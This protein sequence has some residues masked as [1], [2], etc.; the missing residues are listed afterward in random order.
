[1]D[2]E[3]MINILAMK[4]SMREEELRATKLKLK[5]YD[6]LFFIMLGSFTVVC[7]GFV[8]VNGD[9]PPPK[10]T[11]DGVEQTY[12]PTTAKEKLARK[13][14]LKAR[15]TLLMALPNEYQL[16]FNS[17]KNAKS[18]MEAIEK[19]FRGNKESKKTHKTLIKQQYENF[20]GSSSE[21][22]DQTYD[23]LQKLIRQLQILETLSMDDLYNN[24]K[25]YETKVKGSSSSSQNLQ[26]G[27]FMSSN[28]SGSFNQAHG[29]NS[30]NTDSLKEMDLKWQ[31]A[32]LT[33][34]ARRFIKKT[35]RKV[36]ANGYETIKFEK[37]KVEC[38]N[39][40]KRGHFAREYKA[41]KENKKREPVR[42]NVT[43]ETTDAKALV[44]QDGIRYDW[45]DQAKDGPT[46][47]VLMA[48]TSSGSL[49]SS[50]SDS[51]VSDSEDENETETKSKQ[52]KSSFDKVE[53][54]KPNE[55]VKS[56]RES[57]KQV[58]HN[59][60]A[61]H[62]RKNNQSPRGLESVEARLVIYKKNEDIFEENTKILK[63][64][65]HLRDNALT[66]LRKKLEKV[67]DSEDENETETKS[68]QRKSS[69]DKVEFVK[70]NEQV[71]SLRES[72]K[73]KKGVIDSGFSRHMTRNMSYLSEYE[74]I[75]GGY[76][77]FEGDS[78]VG[79][80]D[81]KAD[82]VFF[83]GYSVNSKAFR[84]LNSRTKIIKET[85]H[86][87]FLENKPNVTGS[88]PTWLLDIDT[89]TKSMNYKPVVVGNKSN[90]SADPLF[91]SSS[92]DSPGD[93]FKPSREEEKK[94]AEDPG[95][96]DNE[97]LS[98]E[99]P[100]VNQEKD[101]NVNNTNNINTVSPT[102]NA[103]NIK[104]HA[105]DKDIVYGCVDDPNMH[106]LEEIVYLDDD[107]DVSAEAD[108]TNLDTLSLD[109]E[110]LVSQGYTHEE[111]MDYDEVFAPVARIKAIRLFLAYAS[112]KDFVVY[113]MDVKSA[114]LYG[115]IEEEVYVCQPLG[116]EDSEFPDRVY[117]IEKAL[118][119]L[120]QAPRAWYETLS[121]YLLDNIFQRAITPMET[122]MPLMKDKNA[123]DVDVHLYRSMI[124]SLLY[125]TSSRPDIMFVVCA[126]AR[127]Q[128]TPKVSHLH[129]VK[130]IFR[131]LK[132]Q[133]KLGLWYPKGSPFDLEAYTNS[134]YV[135]ASIDRKSTTG[136]AKDGIEVNFGNSSVNAAGH[137]L[138]LPGLLDCTLVWGDAV[139]EDGPESTS[140]IVEEGELVES[141]LT[142]GITS[143]IGAI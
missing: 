133:P 19:R 130:R 48:Y 135:G 94:D 65:I 1:M 85:L 23:R 64:D 87:N 45:S 86:I 32:M 136:A 102:T 101:A 67:S 63:L 6:R 7:V 112:F 131:Y 10:R 140:V 99:E 128:V 72:V 12:P 26:N 74:E 40:H 95:N 41:L 119:G 2:Y 11:V 8:I 117:K 33:M 20:N 122:S 120:H 142:G 47:F 138:V 139:V 42:R 54:V 53:F 4:K 22:L 57:V 79:K 129:A 82:E 24:L 58:E 43:V 49:S 97:V 105:V 89:L 13:N 110:R 46:N 134:D 51:E 141:S 60:Q 30:A 106:N 52:R 107:E 62:P 50:S 137:Y 9:S 25:I 34:R 44:A 76:V 35:R 121:T 118:Y 108:M 75:D 39:C 3:Q 103:A 125:L 31:M 92:K 113:Q 71:K 73:Q 37:I 56:L 21:G 28:R 69:F 115:K 81:G 96:G 5:L 27:A 143:S 29:S 124:G 80:F 111:G 109:K 127:F 78:K 132:C 83:V 114:F 116:F 17:Y 126:C 91:S 93:G 15:G 16:K 55:Q 61:K 104:D 77:A 100:R 66:E 14:E 38:Y 59:R 84:V 88:R 98:I 123:E 68:K 90:G 18:L 36:G 70:P